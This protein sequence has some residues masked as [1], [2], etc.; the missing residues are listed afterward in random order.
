MEVSRSKNTGSPLRFWVFERRSMSGAWAFA[1]NVDPV[2]YGDAPR[3]PACGKVI[4]MKPWLPPYRVR[5]VGG[6]KTSAPADVI[7]GPGVDSFIASERF[8]TEFKRSGLTGIERWERVQIEGYNDY[9][10]DPTDHAVV[11][12]AYKVAI[13]PFPTT[14][15]KLDEM[16]AVYKGSPPDCAVCGVPRIL[17][18]YEGIVI[19]ETSWKG[20]DVVDV[21]NIGLF[22]VTDR[23]AEFCQAGEFTGIR[24]VPTA[25][26]VPSWAK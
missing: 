15:A 26:Y 23:F 3:C 6:T 17:G 22:V 9:E 11:N 1:D 7:T 8:V 21:I 5:L 16:H 25:K 12:R 18:S 13:L 24:L 2:N 10:G 19:D 14:R 4:G 20:A